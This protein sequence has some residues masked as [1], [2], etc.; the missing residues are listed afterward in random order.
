VFFHIR[1]ASVA[2][3]SCPGTTAQWIID[4]LGNP[5]K[6][7]S[8]FD[9]AIAFLTTPFKEEGLGG[10]STT[11]CWASN[12][13][14]TLVRDAQYGT[15]DL[16]T[17]DVRVEKFWWFDLAGKERYVRIEVKPGTKAHAALSSS[18]FPRKGQRISFAGPVFVDHGA[19]LEV[20][21]QDAIQGY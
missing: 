15:D 11:G 17:M 2:S 4:N 21:P 7:L 12:V 8:G 19:F 20:H 14:G 3:T 16:W 5:E 9:T 1:P 6:A 13:T 10:W 18:R